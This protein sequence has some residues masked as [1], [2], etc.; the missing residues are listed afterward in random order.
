MGMFRFID[1][2]RGLHVKPF[3]QINNN[4]VSSHDIQ[5]RTQVNR[6]QITGGTGQVGFMSHKQPELEKHLRDAMD[7]EYAEL[8]GG[9]TMTKVS[10][11]DENVHVTYQTADGKMHGIRAKFLVGADGKTGFVRK[12]YLE[13]KGVVMEK[14]PKSVF[15]RSSS[16]FAH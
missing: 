15:V 7:K 9:A 2:G 6:R 8:R 12:N 16:M 4:T 3:L 14:S 11:D 10:E 1:G 5:L 13:A